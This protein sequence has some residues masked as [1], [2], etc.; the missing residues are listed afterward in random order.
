MVSLECLA[1][2]RTEGS[3]SFSIA[4]LALYPKIWSGSIY[5]MFDVQ[6]EDTNR[7]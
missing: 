3:E 7:R 6:E 5:S 2:V 4:L 1:E